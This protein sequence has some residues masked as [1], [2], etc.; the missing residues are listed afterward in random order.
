MALKHSLLVVATMVAAA[1]GAALQRAEDCEAIEPS[2]ELRAAAAEMA[3]KEEA[4]AGKPSGKLAEVN[5]PVY[6]HVV[7][8]SQSKADGYLSV[9]RQNLPNPPGASSPLLTPELG[10][11][12]SCHRQWDE[13]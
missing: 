3:I 4:T 13:Q 6:I 8:S 9:R 7:A 11:R 2:A 10:S 5:V 12:C 1:F